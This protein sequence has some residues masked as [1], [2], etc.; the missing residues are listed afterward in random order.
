MFRILGNP[1]MLNPA[2]G[3]LYRVIELHGCQFPV[4]YG[5]YDDQ[6]RENPTVD[7]MPVYPDF[8]AQPRF[9]ADGYRFVTK[10]QDA[11]KHFAGDPAEDAGCA[12]CGYYCHG[13]DLLGICKCRQ[14]RAAI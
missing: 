8:I 11:C 13:E 4:Y 9:T 3:E 2:E 10:M 1:G 12:D 6:D 5:Y 14:Q 7:P